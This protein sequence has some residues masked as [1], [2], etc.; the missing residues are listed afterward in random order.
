M[1]GNL[2]EFAIPGMDVCVY[3]SNQFGENVNMYVNTA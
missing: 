2:G 3:K 1:W